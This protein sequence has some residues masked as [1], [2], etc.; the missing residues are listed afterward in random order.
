MG[1]EHYHAHTRAA[2]RAGYPRAAFARMGAVR[3]AQAYGV[4]TKLVTYPRQPHGIREPK[5]I[6]DAAER[7]LQWL[8][9]YLE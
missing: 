4:D 5:F 7:Q 2:S 3:G 9:K 1:G 8:E 6:I